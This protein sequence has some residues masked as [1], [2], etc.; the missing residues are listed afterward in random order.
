MDFKIVTKSI[1][2]FLKFKITFNLEKSM[3]I[4]SVVMK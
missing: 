4:C 1:I 2:A 3:Y